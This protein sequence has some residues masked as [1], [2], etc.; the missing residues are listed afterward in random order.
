MYASL[1]FEQSPV[2]VAPELAVLSSSNAGAIAENQIGFP[3]CGGHI[4][5]KRRVVNAD[6][7]KTGAACVFHRRS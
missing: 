1:E 7:G 3:N 4:T 5:L 6:S 2:I